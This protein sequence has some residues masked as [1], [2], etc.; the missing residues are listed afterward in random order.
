MCLQ[1]R[2]RSWSFAACADRMQARLMP[3]A[4]PHLLDVVVRLAELGGHLRA[5]HVVRVP[6]MVDAQAVRHQHVPVRDVLHGWPQ[7]LRRAEATYS[8]MYEINSNGLGRAIIRCLIPRLSLQG[9]LLGDD[10]YM[11]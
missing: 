7:S 9:S 3:F 10:R 4:A 8:T 2:A 1:A 11:T 5:A 6:R